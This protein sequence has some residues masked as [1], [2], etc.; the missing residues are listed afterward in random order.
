MVDEELETDYLV[1]GAGA[2]G[3]AFTD[4]LLTHSDATVTMVDRR[5]APGG[6]WI[7]AYPYVR[8]HQPSAFYG[9]SSV[10]LG[11]DAL[12]VAGTNAGYYELAGADEIRAYFAQVMHRRFLP[13]GRVRYFPGSEYLGENRF[14]S[15]LTQESWK[16]RVRRKLVDTTYLEGSIPATSAPP[17]EVADGVRCIPAGEIARIRERPERF[18]VIGAGKTALDTCVWLLEQDVPASSIRWIKPREAWWL[19][20]RFHQ[21]HALLPDLYRSIAIQ[22]EAMAQATSVQD[23]FARLETEAFFLRIDPGVA[24]TMLHGAVI[25]EAELGLLRRIENVVRLG[26]VRRIARDEIVLD[27]GRVPTSEGSVHV[28]CA[29]RGLSR[30]P[31][32]PIFEPGRVTVQPFMWGFACYQFAMLGV[33]EATVQS[34]EEKNRLCPPIAYWD[35]NTDYLSAFL[36]S[37]ANG[38][39]QAAYPALA[40]WAKDT[41]LNPLGGIA[42]YRDAPSVIDA[43][44]RIK[45]AGAAAAGNLVQLLKANTAQPR[46]TRQAH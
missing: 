19:N 9:V 37:L 18:V 2:A 6:H 28:H 36:A 43:R 7:D 20:R 29:A 31:L 25:S 24:P 44:E 8:L 34:D 45:R 11:Q 5:Y 27:E 46:G 30:H 22:L 15:R 41:R 38:R 39:A 17:F 16:V 42:H 10:P 4:A 1:V 35:A 26:H 21:P 13:C 32:R 3:M 14:V 12:D 40:N 33:V 23:L